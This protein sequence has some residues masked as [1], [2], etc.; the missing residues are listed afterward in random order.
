M[1]C[2]HYFQFNLSWFLGG[3]AENFIA[4]RTNIKAVDVTFVSIL[5]YP[6]SSLYDMFILFALDVF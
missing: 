2:S 6:H 5:Y 3:N 4:A 1:F